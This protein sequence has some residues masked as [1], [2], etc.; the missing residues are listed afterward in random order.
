MAL[1]ENSTRRRPRVYVSVQC[2]YCQNTEVI[3]AGKQANGA[4]RYR[5]QNEQCMRRTFLLQYQ[6]RGRIPEIRRQVVDLA[7]NGSGIRDTAR[8]LR[9]SPTTVIAILKKAAALHHVTP[10]LLSLSYS[11]AVSAPAGRAAEIDEM[12]SFDGA[13]ETTRWLW[14]AIDH[15]TGRVLTYVVGTRKDATFRKL[16]AL[17]VPFGIT[18]Y[19]TDKAGVYQRHLPPEQHTVGK[20]PM[21][22]IERKHLTLRTRL[23]RFARKTLCF[24]RSCVMHDLIIGYT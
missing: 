1:H 20:V 7:L 2:P 6:D 19:Y 17:L 22:K 14:H 24:S 16:R 23:K 13:K 4:P 12:W 15:H 18:R 9:I 21:Q 3:K 5:C 11:C 10:A 8:V